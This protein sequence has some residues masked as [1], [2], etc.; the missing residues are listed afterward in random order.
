MKLDEVRLIASRVETFGLDYL[1]LEEEFVENQEHLKQWEKNNEEEESFAE[2]C[3]RGHRMFGRSNSFATRIEVDKFGG[4]GGYGTSS[5]IDQEATPF[6]DTCTPKRKS[7][8][9]NVDRNESFNVVM[10][11][12]AIFV[13]FVQL[14]KGT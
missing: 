12:Y 8:S 9:L 13:M 7:I 14:S 3:L 4:Y 10:R 5:R 2:E 1:P 6:K 11:V